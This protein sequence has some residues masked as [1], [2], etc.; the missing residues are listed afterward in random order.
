IPHDYSK[1]IHNSILFYEAQRSGKLPADNRIPWRG[2]SALDDGLP[3]V[4]LTGGWYDAGDNLKFN[5]PMAYST[6]VIGYGL[7]I[8]K[9]AYNSSNEYTNAMNQ[10]KWPCDYFI[11]CH[12]SP[13][14]YYYQVGNDHSEWTRPEDMTAPRPI[15]K[16]DCDHPGS[17]VAG[18]TAAALAMCSKVWEDEDP[19]YSSLCLRKAKSLYKFA[20]TYRGSYPSDK[21]YMSDKFGDDLGLAAALLHFVT[22]DTTYLDEAIVLYGEY[23]LYGRSYAF[24]WGDVRE[25]V[26]IVI[27]RELKSGRYERNI[28]RYLD[29]WMLDGGLYYTDGGMVFRDLWGSLRYS[30]ATSFIALLA[31]DSGVTSDIT[32]DGVIYREF[33][34]KQIN[35]ILGDNPSSRSYVIGYGNNCPKQPHHRASSCPANF[36]SCNNKNS[37][38]WDGDNH[39]ELIGALVGGP[40]DYDW[41]EDSRYDYVLNEVACD[42]NAGFQSALAGLKSLELRGKLPEACKILMA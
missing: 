21:Y 38:G 39:N 34:C 19:D 33:A 15:Y 10:I 22:R 23:G 5:L 32:D 30:A 1:L 7:I 9:D 25:L 12:V 41:Y 31:A 37:F 6:A 36:E 42:Y 20:M 17:D 24:G 28:K 14:E 18:L 8:W 35:Y 27:W 3:E 26:K 29:T 4:D 11:K 40:D 16:I 13:N 2:D